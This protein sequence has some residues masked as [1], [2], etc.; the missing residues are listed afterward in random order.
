MDARLGRVAVITGGAQGIGRAIA[1][2]LV[3]AGYAVMI[4]DSDD[5]AGQETAEELKS[6][7]T[8]RY[9]R[10]DVGVEVDVRHLMEQTLRDFGRIDALVNNAGIEVR[11]PVEELA[12]A[13]WQRVID[14]NLTGAFLCAKYAAKHLRAT[15]GAIVNIASTR[16]MQSEGNTEAYSA[17][18]GGIVAL[19]HA[20]AIS[21]APAVR[22]NCISPGWI[23]VSQ[24]KKRSRRKPSRITASEHEQ[25]PVGRVGQPEDIAQMVAYLI[26][27]HAGFITGQ[28]FIV[29]G[30]MTRKMI[31]V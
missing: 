11:K 25:Q 15:N 17:S 23:D 20:L 31:Y 10:T 2:H 13:E 1:E 29:D 4:A 9:L 22:V 14:T 3:G 18:K 5:E 16:A 26:G 24:W 6:R 8:L 30:G 19:S 7:G 21:L 27:E 12:V 28:N